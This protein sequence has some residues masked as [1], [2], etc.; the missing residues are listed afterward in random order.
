MFRVW[1]DVGDIVWHYTSILCLNSN[2]QCDPKGVLQH[3]CG[4]KTILFLSVL[5]NV[6][7]FPVVLEGKA[8][9]IV[10]V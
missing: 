9:V 2:E 4:S 6:T 1:S 3:G 10:K 8:P 5:N 7:S